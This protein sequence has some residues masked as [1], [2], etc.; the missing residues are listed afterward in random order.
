MDIRSGYAHNPAMDQDIEL[1]SGVELH[2]EDL[3]READPPVLLIMGL[4]A[5]L[6]LWHNEFCGK[7]IERGY[8]VIRFDNRDVGLSSKL[9]GQKSDGKLIPGL[10]RSFVGLPPRRSTDW[11]IWPATPP[12]CSTISGSSVRMSSGRRWAG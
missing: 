9:H 12:R 4:G 7:L 11:R 8:R 6:T 2:Y 3:G 5:Q 10:L 1:H